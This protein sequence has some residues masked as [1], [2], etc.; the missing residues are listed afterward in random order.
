MYE[1]KCKKKGRALILNISKIVQQL[2]SNT[3][4]TTDGLSEDIFL[5]VST[6]TP[7]I[8]VDLF[9]VD[10]KSR[11]LLAY[12]DDEY[13]GTGWHIP[14]GIIRHKEKIEE[15]IQK[16]A[17]QELGAEVNFMPQ[18]IKI[19]QQL[20]DQRVRDHFI[21]LLFKCTV[22][23]KFDIERKNYGLEE[24]TSGYLK[25]FDEYPN[26]INESMNTLVYSQ[27]AYFDFLQEWFKSKKF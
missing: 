24:T 20:L 22:T 3:Y 26:S 4:K 25:W 19:V 18:P 27:S 21:S 9:I 6:L 17:I 7:L 12:R 23:E 13:C 2:Q 15:R 16:T 10:N 11:V 5:L 8:N 14:G 1:E